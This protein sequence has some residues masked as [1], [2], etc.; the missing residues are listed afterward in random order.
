MGPL[1]WEQLRYN[2]SMFLNK[3][4]HLYWPVVPAIWTE[5]YKCG[6]EFI[7]TSSL[8][9][10]DGDFQKAPTG[11]GSLHPAGRF[12]CAKYKLQVTTEWESCCV[13]TLLVL[14]TTEERQEVLQGLWS[15]NKHQISL[16]YIISLSLSLSAS[17]DF[18]LP[19]HAEWFWRR[20]TQNCS[21][22]C[23]FSMNLFSQTQLR[24]QV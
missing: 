8:F 13:L 22:V 2:K 21:T 4:I 23:S 9:S 6:F 14:N 7:S 11:T 16:L 15:Q 17:E 19:N 3:S 1:N 20:I 24:N 12:C 18:S 5:N 10:W